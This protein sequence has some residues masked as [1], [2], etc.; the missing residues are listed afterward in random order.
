MSDLSRVNCAG[1]GCPER[2][3][4]KRY[5]LRLATELNG[6]AAAERPFVWGSFDLER[7]WF[8]DCPAFVRFKRG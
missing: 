3:D 8:G 7:L 6:V 4:C 5:R 2:D 1:Q